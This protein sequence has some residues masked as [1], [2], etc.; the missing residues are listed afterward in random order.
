[1]KILD[2]VIES[3]H[4]FVVLYELDPDDDWRDERMWIKSGA[5]DRHH[6]ELDYVRRYRDD[7]Q[8]DSGHGRGVRDE[9]RNRWL[10][11]A[12]TWLSM[13]AWD[14][15]A[16]PT[17]TLDAFHGERCWIGVD[18]AERD[19]IAAVAVCFR[20]GDAI[21]GFVR[22]YLPE[23]VVHGAGAGGAGVSAL[24]RQPACSLPRPAT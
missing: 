23:M 9:D 2:R 15:C 8:A 19:D 10:H 18:L 4:T 3:D 20:R 11:S 17:L 12:S 21:V 16:D 24:G 6:A 14:R 5:H 1:M 13:A 7:A 22:G